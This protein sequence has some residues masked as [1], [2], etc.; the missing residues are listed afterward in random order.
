[1]Y[2]LA[3]EREFSRQENWSGLPCLP[4]EDLPNPGIE[5]RSPALQMDLLPSEPPR[6]AQEQ[7]SVQPI[8]S[9]GDLLDPGIKKRSSALQVDSLPSIKPVTAW[10]IQIAMDSRKNKIMVGS[11]SGTVVRS[12]L[13]ETEEKYTIGQEL[14]NSFRNLCVSKSTIPAIC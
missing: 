14:Q 11:V 8:P 2:N 6:E 1:M 9:P 7:W 10:I 4:P 13:S 5:P 3:R 12:S